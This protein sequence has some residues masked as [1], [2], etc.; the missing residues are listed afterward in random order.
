MNLRDENIAVIGLGYVG[1]P[2]AVE[3]GKKRN[4]L[5][6]DIHASRISQLRSGKDHTLEV[7]DDELGEAKHLRYT[8]E[9]T[10]LQ[11]C[12]IFIVTVPTPVD[13]ANRPDM[14]PLVKASETIGKNMPDGA[15]VIY[16]STVYPGATEEVCVPVLER[17]SGKKFNV[18]FFCGYSPER[19]NPGDKEH[20]LPTIK[21]ITSG[22]TP[23]VADAVDR[24][25]AQIIT[26]GT[27]KA[28]SIKVAEAAK[29]IENTQR[30]VSIALMNELSLIFHRLGIDTLEVLQAAGTKWNFQRFR[31]GLVGG[32]CIGVDPY[33]L[34]HK[35]QEVGYHPEVILAGR[36][37][38]DNMAAHVAN[39][40]I[41]LM[42]GKGLPVLG[43][44]ILVLGLTFKENC[45]DVRNTKVADIVRTLRGY[46]AQV[47]VYDPWVDLEEAESEYGIRCLSE[48]PGGGEY[49]AIVLAVGHR[50]FVELGASGIRALGQ[51]NAVVFDVKGILPLGAA[52]CRL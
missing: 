18:D 14:T 47:D 48:L 22:S 49:A 36:R 6:F 37:I 27:H 28:S 44:R 13:Q 15:V 50:Q 20:R 52:D 11:A 7:S 19:I 46:N 35:A 39:E 25:Y 45:P 31:P 10:E 33:Y 17:V 3:F 8:N 29:V 4:V 9:P 23:E 38:N 34:T 24:L 41:K 2:L 32:H 40:T 16:E 42:L 5:G 43:E 26:A 1:L 30:D 21:K 51:P 12:K